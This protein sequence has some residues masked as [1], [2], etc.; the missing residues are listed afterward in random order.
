MHS[1]LK[2]FHQ[3]ILS[4]GIKTE[5]KNMSL[6]KFIWLYLCLSKTLWNEGKFLRVILHCILGCLKKICFLYWKLLIMSNRR[7][8]WGSEGKQGICQQSCSQVFRNYPCALQRSVWMKMIIA[9]ISARN[10]SPS[11]VWMQVWNLSTNTYDLCFTQF[12]TI[13]TQNS[14]N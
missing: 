7:W 6:I 5:Q 10:C 11:R 12:C 14:R 3:E 13:L 8:T 2:Y 4:T 9:P 1:S